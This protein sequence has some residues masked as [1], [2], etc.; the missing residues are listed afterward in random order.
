MT[1][2]GEPDDDGNI[3]KYRIPMFED[4]SGKSVFDLHDESKDYIAINM[5]LKYLKYYPID[6]HSRLLA[7]IMPQIIE[8]EL[9]NTIAYFESRSIQTFSIKNYKKGTIPDMNTEG[10]VPAHLLE[11]PHN[12]EKLIEKTKNYRLIEINYIDMPLVHSF[13]SDL[14]QDYFANLGNTS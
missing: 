11:K 6:H 12:M 9:S 2:G 5:H 14:C 3:L 4:F 13:K 8:N 10:V 7:K 1:N